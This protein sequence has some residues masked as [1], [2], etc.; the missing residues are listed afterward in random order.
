MTC[1]EKPE[2]QLS[3]QTIY[4]GIK[5][6][7]KAIEERK[8]NMTQWEHELKLHFY[9]LDFNRDDRLAKHQ[10]RMLMT[11]YVGYPKEIAYDQIDDIMKICDKDNIGKITYE[12]LHNIMVSKPHAKKK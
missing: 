6:M 7:N 2:H 4:D 12:Q 3:R 11:Q 5:V 10:V 9:K 8:G 1:C